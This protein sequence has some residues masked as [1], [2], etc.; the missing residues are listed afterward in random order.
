MLRC[1]RD[2][3]SADIFK[4]IKFAQTQVRQLTRRTFARQIIQPWSLTAHEGEYWA[5]VIAPP[6]HA[7]VWGRWQDP[8]DAA[9]F[10]VKS[11]QNVVN[12]LAHA[13]KQAAVSWPVMPEQTAR[14]SVWKPALWGHDGTSA[15]LR[16]VAGPADSL[17]WPGT[18]VRVCAYRQVRRCW[19]VFEVREKAAPSGWVVRGCPCV[20]AL[21]TNPAD[22]TQ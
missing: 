9:S 18:P 5:R 14:V 8:Q 3:G 4:I 21:K 19:R 10:K 12:H 6:K 20:R 15:C 2:V 22:D 16:M 17:P 7:R 11:W 13:W 1:R